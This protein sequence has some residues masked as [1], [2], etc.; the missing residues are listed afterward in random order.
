[1][2]AERLIFKDHL[3]VPGIPT[4]PLIAPQGAQSSCKKNLPKL[5]VSAVVILHLALIAM[6]ITHTTQYHPLNIIN[7]ATQTSIEATM[8]EAPAEP[9][10]VPEVVKAPPVLTADN[11]TREIDQ[12]DVKPVVPPPEPKV[13]PTK[14][15]PKPVVRH[16]T[17][18]EK[19]HPVEPVKPSPVQNA[20]VAERTAIPAT[21]Q[22]QMLKSVP[23]AAPR[24]VATVGCQVPAPDYPRRAKRLQEQGEVLIRLIINSDG[25]VKHREI[26]RSS[27]FDDL[28]QAAME[29]VSRIRCN[30]YMENGQAIS[31]MTIQPITFKLSS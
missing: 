5:A 25:T 14:P 21:S 27:G 26:A 22:G 31:V 3:S 30:P 15:K 20:K 13:V 24:N 8:V 10:P 12:D 4:A 18:T 17:L 2:K 19:T 7:P 6:A 28:D 1:M 29:A 23:N 16:K 9:V 11:S